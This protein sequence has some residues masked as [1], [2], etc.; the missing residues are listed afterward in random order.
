MMTRENKWN[1]QHKSIRESWLFA[2]DY[3][4]DGARKGRNLQTDPS[5]ISLFARSDLV[6]F[7]IDV[8]SPSSLNIPL[9]SYSN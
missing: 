5:A 9:C 4:K 1:Y 6:Q 2:T 8:V 3:P 7:R